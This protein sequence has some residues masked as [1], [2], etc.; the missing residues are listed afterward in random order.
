MGSRAAV[1][2]K[3]RVKNQSSYKL[4]GLKDHIERR[5]TPVAFLHF[6]NASSEPTE[7]VRDGIW[8]TLLPFDLG[9]HGWTA[10]SARLQQF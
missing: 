1:G 2:V 9:V 3:D 7:G 8:I 6:L 4:F 5:T 10:G